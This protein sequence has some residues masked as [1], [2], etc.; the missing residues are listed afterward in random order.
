MASV[1]S[2]IDAQASKQNVLM[3][4]RKICFQESKLIGS[5]IREIKGLAHETFPYQVYSLSKD[6]CRELGKAGGAGFQ[7][8]LCTL[9]Y[10]KTSEADWDIAVNLFTR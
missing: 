8:A 5:R 10:A 2:S 4:N 7:D 6:R 3:Q 1:L 9:K